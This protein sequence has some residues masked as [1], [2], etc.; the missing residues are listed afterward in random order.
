[1]GESPA[2][3][4]V[5]TDKKLVGFFDSGCLFAVVSSGTGR[6]PVRAII[7]RGV[8]VTNA[9]DIHTSGMAEQVCA[10]S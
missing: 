7:D 4:G 2:V 10:L 5:R 3:T 6:L 9:A 8:A 1:M